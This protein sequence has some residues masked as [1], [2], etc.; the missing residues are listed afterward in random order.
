MPRLLWR[1]AQY[2]EA[3]SAGKIKFRQKRPAPREQQQE[4]NEAREKRH[5]IVYKSTRTS[6]I[7][8]ETN[9]IIEKDLYHVPKEPAPLL[10]FQ[11]RIQGQSDRRRGM[12]EVE[13]DAMASPY[14]NS[15]PKSQLVYS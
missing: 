11:Q 9:P 5:P 4:A 6:S 1:L 3:E 15:T 14:G 7:L 13:L 8:L 10:P 2:L 12:N